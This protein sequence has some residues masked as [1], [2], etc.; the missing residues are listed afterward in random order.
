M[1][2]PEMIKFA[3]ELALGA[4]KSFPAG[5]LN[6][7]DEGGIKMAIGH[8]SGKVI[9]NFGTPVAWVGFTPDEA[10]Q[11]AQSIINH[12]AECRN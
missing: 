3:R 2:D 5:H 4:T 12:A 1:N 10:L 6:Q 8:E 11:F 7:T 9:V